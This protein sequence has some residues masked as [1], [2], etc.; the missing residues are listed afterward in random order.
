MDLELRH[1]HNQQ[2]R[3]EAEKRRL[4]NDL[5]LLI[6]DFVPNEEAAGRSYTPLDIEVYKTLL[7]FVPDKDAFLKTLIDFKT[8]DRAQCV[9]RSNRFRNMKNKR[10]DILK[11]GEPLDNLHELKSDAQQMCYAAKMSLLQKTS[12]FI[13]KH[14]CNMIETMLRNE[15]A[16]RIAD[17]RVG[18][19]L[20][21]YLFSVL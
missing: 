5:N 9:G 17:L 11:M 2:K 7:S 20:Y 14:C 19:K 15:K 13:E 18:F 16:K 12:D 1:E 3:R 6:A 8:L 21:F 10:D 4:E